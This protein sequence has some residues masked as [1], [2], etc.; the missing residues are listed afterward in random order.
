MLRFIAPKIQVEIA[1]RFNCNVAREYK[2]RLLDV[3]GLHP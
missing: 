3:S 1:Q 2:S